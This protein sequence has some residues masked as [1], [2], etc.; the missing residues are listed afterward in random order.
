M[1]DPFSENQEGCEVVI[2]F[3]PKWTTNEAHG[4][5]GIL[6]RDEETEVTPFPRL[7]TPQTIPPSYLHACAPLSFY[8]CSLI[9]GRGPVHGFPCQNVAIYR[10]AAILILNK[11]FLSSSATVRGGM[12]STAI[13]RSQWELLEQPNWRLGPWALVPSAMGTR[14]KPC[15]KC[16]FSAPHMYM[17]LEE[18]RP[19]TSP[20]HTNTAV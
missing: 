6:R 2:F 19:Q 13:G 8:H 12:P 17:L 4:P 14:K 20:D 5:G 16:P 9:L 11:L 18:T 3:Y 15:G 7:E 10:A 1:P